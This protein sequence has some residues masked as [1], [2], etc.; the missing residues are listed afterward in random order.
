MYLI[1]I[2]Y[3]FFFRKRMMRLFKRRCS[4]PNPQ[5]ENLSTLSEDD[6]NLTQS[7]RVPSN[8]DFS[9]A[10]K[11]HLSGWGKTWGKLKRG[12]SSELLRANKSKRPSWSPLKK[13]VETK[14]NSNVGTS[15]GEKEK[16]EW[17]Q[18][19]LKKIYEMYKSMNDSA[20]KRERPSKTLRK[21]KCISENLELSQQQLLDYLIL[22]KP[23]SQELDKIFIFYQKK[24]NQEK[25]RFKSIFSRSSK[26]DDESDLKLHPKNSSTDSLTSLINFILP[27]KSSNI[28]PKLPTKFKSDE[29]GYGS[30]ST[31]AAS[32]DSPIGSIKSQI[33]N[34]SQEE[35]KTKLSTSHFY[36]DDTDTA[37]E[38]ELDKTLTNLNGNFKLGDEV[39]RLNGT[40]IKGCPLTI[41]KSYLEPKNGELEIVISRLPT[42]QSNK[43]NKRRNSFLGE[44]TSA[45]KFPLFSPSK[46]IFETKKDKESLK[47]RKYS[48]SSNLPKVDKNRMVGLSDIFSMR[49]EDD[50]ESKVTFSESPCS[51]KDDDKI[52]FKKP[53]NYRNTVTSPK[54]IT[55]M[56]KFSYS[57]DT[58]VKPASVSS[59]ECRTE[60]K[61]PQRKTVIFHKGPG[62]KS[63]GFS[64]VG[65]KDSPRGPMGIYVKTIFPQG[66]AAESGDEIISINGT[67]FE[68]LSHNEAVQLFKNIKCG[69][70][71]MEI[72]RRQQYKLFSSS[73]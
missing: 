2:N 39:V 61:R 13:N 25:S 4:D 55:G 42:E 50:P 43:S 6:D 71:S 49:Q 30:D 64:I 3:V 41:A 48:L 68:G 7:S 5:L 36:T 51:S 34:I 31:K 66:Q 62:L 11:S 44:N 37:E 1:N 47:T 9:E 24:K 72:A 16:V 22:I 56:R 46:D 33:S 8:E 58:Y 12:D 26:S 28:S 65:G 73:L 29:S 57:S 63:L 17:S 10:T 59:L 20:N 27:R 45:M 38:D 60:R 23:N 52:I 14:N 35:E 18:T 19:D 70:V 32:I 40:R 15:R 69:E 53:E 67:P 21:A 54:V